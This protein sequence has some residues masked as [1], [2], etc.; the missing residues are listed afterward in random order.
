MEKLKIEI[1]SIRTSL[2]KELGAWYVLDTDR[3]KCTGEI[4]W[5][6]KEGDILILSGDWTAWQGMKQFKFKSAMPDLPTDPKHQLHYCC[7]RANGIGPKLEQDIWERL[8]EH[9][10]NIKSGDVPKMTDKKLQNF[11]MSIE[12]LEAETEKVNLIAFLM[13]KGAT[14]NLATAAWGKWSKNALGII[15]ANCY[16]L[17]DLP[18]YGFG[19]VDKGIR[20]QFGITNDDPRRIKAAILYCMKLLT[21]SG[22]TAIDWAVIMTQVKN[23]IIGVEHQ[24]IIDEFE[25]LFKTGELVPFYNSQRIALRKDHENET[26]IWE[27]IKK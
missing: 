25:I 8:G 27:F 19:D 20:M 3:G 1:Q 18:N 6:V 26:I 9:W 10:M 15:N 24:L 23:T 21:K 12:A 2:P 11:K 14:L 13:G 7:K 4:G 5:E 22:S 16:R 17:S